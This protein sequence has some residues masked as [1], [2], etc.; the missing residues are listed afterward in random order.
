MADTTDRTYPLTVVTMPAP[1]VVDGKPVM[2]KYW[3]KS[4]NAA[5][6]KVGPQH[7]HAIKNP[8]P[9]PHAHGGYVYPPPNPAKP[10]AGWWNVNDLPDPNAHSGGFYWLGNASAQ[11][12]TSGI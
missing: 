5:T 9:V 12:G 1:A 6:L 8:T 10:F 3:A 7:I 2:P 11:D 4:E